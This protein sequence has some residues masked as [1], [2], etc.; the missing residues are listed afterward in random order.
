MSAPSFAARRGMQVAH[1]KTMPWR[2]GVTGLAQA[3]ACGE[4]TAVEVVESHIARIEEVN[5]RLNA[6]VWSRYDQARAEAREIDRHRRAGHA[7]GPLA[8][9]PIT[10]KECLDLA[11]SPSTFGLPHRRTHRATSDDPYVARLRDAGAIVLGKTNVA[12]C[13]GFMET[14]N[15][16]YGR[17]NHPDDPGRSPGGSSGGQAAIIAAGGSPLGLSTDLAGSGR[18]PAAYC[19]IIG[20][21]STA[22]RIPDLTPGVHPLSQVGLLARSVEDAALGLDIAA[23]S[24]DT[25]PLRNFREVDMTKLRIGF[26]VEDGL[27]APSA[28]YR[29]AVNEAGEALERCGA[30][31]VELKKPNLGEVLD[32]FGRILLADRMAGTLRSLGDAPRARQIRTTTRLARLPAAL[33]PVV[34]KLLRLSGRPQVA[35]RIEWL[36]PCSVDAYWRLCERQLDHRARWLAT[37]DEQRV[38]IVLSPA[39]GLPAVKHGATVELGLMGAYTALYNLLGWPAGVV[40]VTRVRADEETT[41]A[42]TRDVRGRVALATEQGSAGLPIAVQIA[43]RPWREDQVLAVMAALEGDVTF[44][45]TLA[46]KLG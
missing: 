8:G 46:C 22:G 30:Q 36:R 9:V 31:V 13:L 45:G 10:I 3:I 11:G 23:R 34:Q 37:L 26:F 5:P 2:L 25:P 35:A 33:L 15:P 19:G 18:Q 14:D 32:L 27:F 39:T 17:T 20:L 7:L 43:A 38:D 16:L 21:L 28:A 44:D 1:S 40:P 4:L 24:S 41:T 6:V 12:Q 42:R 29:R